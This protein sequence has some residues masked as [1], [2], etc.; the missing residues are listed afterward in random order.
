MSPT[1]PGP[2]F[3]RPHWMWLLDALARRGPLDARTGRRSR[4]ARC[5]DSGSSEQR[6]ERCSRFSSSSRSQLRQAPRTHTAIPSSSLLGARDVPSLGRRRNSRSLRRPL[7]LV[8]GDVRWL[9]VCRICGRRGSRR[10][11]R[12]MAR[13]DRV[14]GGTPAG[15]PNGVSFIDVPSESF[16]DAH[17]L[18]EAGRGHTHLAHI[19]T[20]AYVG[21]D[22]CGDAHLRRVVALARLDRHRL[23]F[24][25]PD[26][27]H[28]SARL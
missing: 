2:G 11:S 27:R 20:A 5:S 8:R 25:Q 24:D 12:S 10:D 16:G 6:E 14:L 1:S 3:S 4:M 26:E 28:D 19:T 18:L 7:H 23:Y 22:G 9:S 15:R 13:R 17:A 21:F